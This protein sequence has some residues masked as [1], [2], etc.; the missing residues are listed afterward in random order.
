MITS[1]TK[2]PFG[3]KVA[4]VETKSFNCMVSTAKDGLFKKQSIMFSDLS[5]GMSSRRHIAKLVFNDI[6]SSSQ[7]IEFH[8][9][10][11]H[12]IDEAGMNGKSLGA[13]L[14]DLFDGLKREGIGFGTMMEDL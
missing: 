10:I 7:R 6:I 11:V 12:T 9:I 8:D 14:M 2:Y 13:T 5:G 4:T 3:G 1:N